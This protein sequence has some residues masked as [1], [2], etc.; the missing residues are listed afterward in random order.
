MLIIAFVSEIASAGHEPDMSTT[1]KI[2]FNNC[3]IKFFP[4]CIKPVPK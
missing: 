1:A 2:H 4:S 3:R